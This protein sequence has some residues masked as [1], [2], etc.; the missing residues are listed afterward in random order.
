[1]PYLLRWNASVPRNTLMNTSSSELV[2][3]NSLINLLV[4]VLVQLAVWVVFGRSQ[5]VRANGERAAERV[6]RRPVVLAVAVAELV[7]VVQPVVQADV[8]LALVLRVVARDDRVVRCPAG[9]RASAAGY[10]FSSASPLALS[11][12]AGMMLPGN[13]SAGRRIDDHRAPV[14]NP[15]LAPRSSLKSPVRIFAVGTV[16]VLVWVAK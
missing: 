5:S 11:C 7:L 4:I 1:M 15:L 16:A 10:A 2:K 14:K 6:H 12:P 9:I 13:G 3:L 8:V